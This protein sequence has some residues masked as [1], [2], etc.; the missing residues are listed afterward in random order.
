[1][2]L[3]CQPIATPVPEVSSKALAAF[4]RHPGLPMTS[5]HGDQVSAGITH[6]REIHMSVDV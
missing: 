3:Q 2:N 6:P 1:M 5:G 4:D